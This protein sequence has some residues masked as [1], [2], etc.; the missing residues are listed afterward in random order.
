MLIW[1]NM[2]SV[3]SEGKWWACYIFYFNLSV[4][5]IRKVYILVTY[6]HLSLQKIRCNIEQWNLSVY[7][8]I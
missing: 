2:P 3:L 6:K 4:N 8:S 7:R 5:K 1:F